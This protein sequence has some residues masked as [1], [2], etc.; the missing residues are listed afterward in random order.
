MLE[1]ITF[2]AFL[3]SLKT[4]TD[5]VKTLNEASSSMEHSSLKLQIA[6]LMGAIADMKMAAV[7]LRDQVSE[8]EKEIERLTKALKIKDDVIRYCD[9]YYTKGNEG[10][11]QGDPYCARCWEHAGELYH[12]TLTAV[13]RN[14]ECQVCSS[15]FDRTATPRR[16]N[17]DYPSQ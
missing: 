13:G 15:I 5:L 8:K 12:L 2:T 17:T 11:P 4:A 6:E 7:D 9:A 14:H 3:G 16:V 1:P 10:K